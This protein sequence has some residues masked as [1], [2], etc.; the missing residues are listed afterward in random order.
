MNQDELSRI[1][2]Q[3]S[4]DE[5]GAQIDAAILAAAHREVKAKP[6]RSTS[7][8][9]GI[10]LSVAAVLVLSATLTLMIL[11]EP[12]TPLKIDSLPA[13]EEPAKEQVPAAGKP[14]GERRREN[15]SDKV[16][17]KAEM[18]AQPLPKR[19]SPLEKSKS[20]SD[21]ARF[22]SAQQESQNKAAQSEQRSAAGAA[23][24]TAPRPAAEYDSSS[25]LEE[26]APEKWL[27]RIEKLRAEGNIEEAK[28]SLG[29]FKKRFPD[30]ALPDWAKEE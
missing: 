23:P 3:G 6:R 21:E 8:S 16:E 19:D 25:Q 18:P 15:L 1:Y 14:E 24:Q 20:R 7:L 17:K 26:V 5:P 30:Y 4:R 2:R 28:K 29:E 9:W 10:P 12:E 27:A 13:A 11:N 22:E